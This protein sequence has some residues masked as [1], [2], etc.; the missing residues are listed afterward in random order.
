MDTQDPSDRYHHGKILKDFILKNNI[1]RKGGM[2]RL[3]SALLMTRQGIYGLYKQ[4]VIKRHNRSAII[5]YFNLPDD[6][7]PNPDKKEDEYNL[8]FREYVKGRMRIEQLEDDL[9]KAQARYI[10]RLHMNNLVNDPENIEGNNVCV[11]M[12]P[13]AEK[14]VHHYFDPLYLDRLSKIKV[15]NLQ[16]GFAFE[17]GDVSM[18]K[19]GCLPSNLALSYDLIEFYENIEEN[20]PY[21]IVYKSL[22]YGSGIVCRY[23]SYFRRK[24]RLF[25]PNKSFKDIELSQFEVEQVW[26][27]NRFLELSSE[28]YIKFLEFSMEDDFR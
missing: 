19:V 15:P 17:V 9:D 3:A 7:F 11:I 1:N 24:F 23:L 13:S 16:G 5:E 22:Q 2:N 14:Y 18:V 8:M 12:A 20:T 21:I 26:V 4:E 25:S 10:T 6:F 27:V 28:Q